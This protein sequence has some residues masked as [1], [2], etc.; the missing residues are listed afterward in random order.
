MEA[1]HTGKLPRASI[2]RVG[3]QSNHVVQKHHGKCG[4]VCTFDAADLLAAQRFSEGDV[5]PICLCLSPRTHSARSV[6]DLSMIIM[7]CTGTTLLDCP[8]CPV[9]KIMN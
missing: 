7:T 6:P 9:S 1:L 4:A 5:D 3:P 2:G 8:L